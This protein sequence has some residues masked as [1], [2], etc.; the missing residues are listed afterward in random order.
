MI[1]FTGLELL[2]SDE[3]DSWAVQPC[4]SGVAAAQEKFSG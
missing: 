1:S 4:V 2:A 3:W